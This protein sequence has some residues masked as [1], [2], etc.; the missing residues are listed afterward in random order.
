MTLYTRLFA[1][2]TAV[3][4]S[5]VLTVSFIHLTNA[6]IRRTYSATL[7]DILSK[8]PPFIP[9]NWDVEKGPDP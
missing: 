5:L 8:N 1:D 2:F 4:A 3:G 6:A 7:A 9:L